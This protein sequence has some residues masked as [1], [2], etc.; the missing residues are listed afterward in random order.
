M[1]NL[2]ILQYANVLVKC[3]LKYTALFCRCF[4]YLHFSHVNDCVMSVI[5]LSQSSLCLSVSLCVLQ[6][7]L[8]VFVCDFMSATGLK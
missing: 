8:P 2:A 3:L 5:L 7:D 4:V 6:H 1:V